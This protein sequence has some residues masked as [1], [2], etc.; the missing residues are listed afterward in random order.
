MFIISKTYLLQL[1]RIRSYSSNTGLPTNSLYIAGHYLRCKV[2]QSKLLSN[3]NLY[4]EIVV[5]LEEKI[6]YQLAQKETSL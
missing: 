6:S 3:S 4:T 5:S 2:L 1:N